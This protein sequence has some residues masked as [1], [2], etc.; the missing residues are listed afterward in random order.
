MRILLV[1]DDE[2]LGRAVQSALKH[3]HYT[4]DWLVD[5]ENADQALRTENFDA[6]LLDLNLPRRSGIEVLVNLRKRGVPTPVMIFTARDSVDDRILGLDSGA[7]DYLPKPFELDELLA[8]LRALM[9][10]ASG[11][12]DPIISHGAL[13]LNPASHEIALNGE[14]Q[15]ISPKE[16]TLLQKLLENIGRVLSREQLAQS[17][18][19]WSKDIDSNTVEVHIHNLRKKLG[20]QFIRTVRGVGYM[21]KKTEEQ[22]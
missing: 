2:Q 10:R 12:A 5:G 15:E 7:D 6:V 3:E 13:T 21:I 1:E 11:R 18:Y 17:L 9:R 4:V 20:N 22:H 14:V 8:R 16:F 19:G